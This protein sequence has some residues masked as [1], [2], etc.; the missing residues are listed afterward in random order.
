MKKGTG[1]NTPIKSI[2]Q[3]FIKHLQH[4]TD[5]GKDGYTPKGLF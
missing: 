1:F 5:M 3:T 4:V 2:Q